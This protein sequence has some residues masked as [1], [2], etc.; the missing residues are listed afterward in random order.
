M[1]DQRT[2]GLGSLTRRAQGTPIK[3]G[4]QRRIVITMDEE[5]FLRIKERAVRE[6]RSM[7]NLMVRFLEEAA[8]Q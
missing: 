1:T 2:A 8:T 5:L 6:G 7:S 4:A 3:G